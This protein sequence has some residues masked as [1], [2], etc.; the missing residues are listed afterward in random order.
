MLPVYPL[1]IILATI[2]NVNQQLTELTVGCAGVVGGCRL[3]DPL[4]KQ[5]EDL[6]SMIEKATP[7]QMQK[8]FQLMKHLQYLIQ[9]VAASEEAEQLITQGWRFIGTLPNGR[10]ILQK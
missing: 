9:K 10:V 2:S 8:M 4:L 1:N 7:E 6:H 3:V 5:K